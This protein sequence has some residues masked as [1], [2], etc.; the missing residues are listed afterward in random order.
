MY[1]NLSVKTISKTENQPILGDQNWKWTIRNVQCE[2]IV[3][4][5]SK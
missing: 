5:D 4:L 3:K 1:S 2:K